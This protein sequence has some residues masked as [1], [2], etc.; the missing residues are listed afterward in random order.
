MLTRPSPPQ[1]PQAHRGVSLLEVL[2]SIVIFSVGLLGM[3]AMQ[4]ATLRFEQGAWAR[5]AVASATAD[6]ADRIR[7]V[8]VA[9]PAQFQAVSTYAAERTRMSTPANLVPA[10]NCLTTVCTPAQLVDYQVT[11]W[12][13]SLVD[14]LP[15][16]AGFIITN[17]TPGLNLSYQVV[18]AWADKDLLDETNT[19][20]Q[21]P[22]CPDPPNLAA[23]NI[24]DRI[25][26][27]T[28]CPAAIA[29][30]AGVRCAIMSVA[31]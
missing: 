31:P 7:T 19:L 10:V 26:A 4:T 25:V 8:T 22:V 12:R 2:V 23:T 9:T 1:L 18:L 5:S 6:M 24:A 29:A 13:A 17:G 14:S 15:Q 3:L 28:C 30:P 20:I 27:R 11:T 16:P 21:A